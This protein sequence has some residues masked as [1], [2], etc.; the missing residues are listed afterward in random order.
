M[1]STHNEVYLESRKMFW[2]RIFARM[3]SWILAEFLALR[4]VFCFGLGDLYFNFQTYEHI[5]FNFQSSGVGPFSFWALMTLQYTIFGL[6]DLQ[7]IVAFVF[8]LSFNSVIR[9]I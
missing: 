4:T 2:G 8:G 1:Y 3:D 7:I 5:Y 9:V 6:A